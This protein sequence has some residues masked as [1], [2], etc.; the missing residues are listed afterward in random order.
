ME[1]STL[2]RAC[3]LFAALSNHTRL[4]ITEI[5]IE[6]E[7]T[8]GEVADAMGISLSGASQH[9]AQLARVGVLVVERRGVARVYRI[10][11]PRIAM[12][13]GLIEEFCHVHGLYGA[14]L[15]PSEETDALGSAERSDNTS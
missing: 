2:D 1:S 14:D 12:I 13:L 7:R 10:R 9:L 3:E 4:R 5:V 6:K 8:V 11:G 15:E